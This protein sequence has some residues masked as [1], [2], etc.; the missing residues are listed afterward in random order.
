MR[1][2]VVAV[3]GVVALAITVLGPA[4]AGSA[5][6]QEKNVN[7][8]E[9]LRLARALQAGGLEVE[10]TRTTDRSV[11]LVE[12][13]QQARGDDLFISVHN[14][15]STDR[16]TRGSEVYS[17]VGN[18]TGAAIAGRVL[19]GIT[20]RA[21]TAARGTFARVGDHGDYYSVLRNC[22]TTALIVEGAFL[23]NPDEARLLSQ[24]G[25]RQRL[26]D[27]V[28]DG[29][30]SQFATLRGNTG[31]GPP[32]PKVL[33]TGHV[34]AAPQGLQATRL[35]G[36]GVRVAWAPVPLA[37]A[38][39]VWRDGSLV[40]TGAGTGFEETGLTAGPHRYEVRAVLEALNLRVEESNA[41]G[42]DTVLPWRVVIDPGHGGEDPGAIGTT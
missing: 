17:Q 18:A 9:A 38:Y 30:L 23:S 33:P 5:Q 31:A 25:F 1:R 10:M 41:T 2:S 32:A 13:A 42:V 7:L 37:T 36:R 12:R 29:V 27:G 11:G 34:L 3:A 20:S 35:P 6:L 15:S 40:H 8:D 14:N 16:A 4:Q 21:G 39:E 24:A 26:A 19:S 22:P 28:A